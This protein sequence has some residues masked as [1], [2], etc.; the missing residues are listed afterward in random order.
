MFSSC[1]RVLFRTASRI[2][3]ER[4]PFSQLK[5]AIY[6]PRLRQIA[7]HSSRSWFRPVKFL[8]GETFFPF[9]SD[10]RAYRSLIRGWQS[11]VVALQIGDNERTR[12]STITPPHPGT[13]SCY[14]FVQ[15]TFA[16]SFVTDHPFR[17]PVCPA[18][19]VCWN[20]QH[21]ARQRGLSSPRTDAIPGS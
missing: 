9:I 13:P 5:V 15:F 10:R 7:T 19:L 17:S 18:P 14:R 4:N 6:W 2:L 16:P 12:S 8:K 11:P 3:S 20:Q 1:T 21:V